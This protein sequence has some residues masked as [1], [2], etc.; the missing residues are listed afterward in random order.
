[1]S[2]WKRFLRA[3]KQRDSIKIMLLLT[4][5]ALGFF[6]GAVYR[7]IGLY[8]LVNAPVEYVLYGEQKRIQELAE[9]PG[10]VAA[11]PQRESSR[12]LLYQG[13]EYQVSCVGLS[14]EYLDKVYCIQSRGVTETI[15]MN[16]P[17]L[18][19]LQTA[20]QE[21]LVT[22]LVEAADG[23]GTALS[24]QSL[25]T[26]VRLRLA[27]GI[28]DQEKPLAFLAAKSSGQQ[29]VPEESG[30]LGSGRVRICFERQDLDGSQQEQ[31]ERLGFSVENQEL[32][33][34]EYEKSELLLRMK[35]EA[36]I[37]VL[38][39]AGAVGAWKFGKK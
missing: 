5:A 15:Y 19:Q 10:A 3:R 9:L 22:C 21:L 2:W 14:E 35:Y 17:A 29:A 11:S 4:A 1:M 28:R 13:Q 31:L 39:A 33:K 20:E 34:T 32:L 12:T 25:Q 30:I 8:R 26:T 37:G 16:R 24:S 7:G 36:L 23:S 38:L 6:A 27:E 18:R